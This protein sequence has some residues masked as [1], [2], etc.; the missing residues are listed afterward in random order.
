[1]KKFIQKNTQ[2]DILSSLQNL[3]SGFCYAR[4]GTTALDILRY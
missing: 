4:L 1:M 3:F 2:D